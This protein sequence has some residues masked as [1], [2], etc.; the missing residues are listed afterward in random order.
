MGPR[1][2]ATTARSPRTQPRAGTPPLPR[3][4]TNQPLL[5]PPVR[6][7]VLPLLLLGWC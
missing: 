1:T 6:L 7:E 4:P 2:G 5:Q 3:L